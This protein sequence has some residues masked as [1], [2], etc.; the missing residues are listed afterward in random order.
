MALGKTI[1][2]AALISSFVYAVAVNNA[3]FTRKAFPSEFLF[4]VASSAYQYEG[5]YAEDGKGLSNWDWFSHISEGTG[6]INEKGVRYYN[7]LINELLNKGMQPF[8]TLCHYDI[9]QA[10]EDQYGSWLNQRIAD[11]F[12]RYAEACFEMFGDRVKYWT[13]FNEPNVFIPVGYETG[14]YPP[15]RCSASLW[16][17]S[18][19]NSS[20][21]P[22]IAGHNLLRAHAYAVDVYRRKFQADQG[23]FIGIVISTLWFEPLTNSSEDLEA[24]DRI[25]AFHN[26]WYLDPIVLGEYPTIMHKFLGTRLP[27]ITE[28]LRHKL[29]GSFDFIGLNYYSALY[30]TSASYLENSPP[31]NIYRDS[32]TTLTEERDGI[33]IGNQMY[34]PSMICVPYGIEKMVNYVKTRY[35]NPLLF[36]SENGFGNKGNDNLPLLQKL[37]DTFRVECIQNALKYLEKSI[38]QGADVRGYFVWSLLDNFEWV[39]GY[40]SKFG[41]YHID[42][43][44]GLQRYPKLSAYWYRNFLQGKSE[45]HT[46]EFLTDFTKK[47][48]GN[49]NPITAEA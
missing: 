33:P 14:S 44:D 31:R 48:A 30:A 36:L 49:L 17:C 13:T 35:S 2:V 45:S 28:D 23:G 42:F 43:T 37:N 4:G 47:H 46:E 3:E 24:K 7:D 22:Y 38:R 12:A 9:P 21:E 18:A 27:T 25:H 34:P 39:F 32:L 26:A 6:E 41:M 20:T 8:V 1:Y 29:R 11:D 19:G 10:L 15:Q 40:T 5:A 16:N